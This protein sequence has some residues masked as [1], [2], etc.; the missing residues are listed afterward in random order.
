MQSDREMMPQLT[1]GMVLWVMTRDIR[2][3]TVALMKS[4]FVHLQPITWPH[5]I[6]ECYKICTIF[7][8]N[9]RLEGVVSITKIAKPR[10]DVA[11]LQS[12]MV[13]V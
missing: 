3:K 13:R 4:T 7:S 2:W 6:P 5:L 11:V 9:V 1:P 12:V 10:N 8:S